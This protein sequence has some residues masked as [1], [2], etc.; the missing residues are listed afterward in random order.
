MKLHDV[1]IE[2]V[3]KLFAWIISEYGNLSGYVVLFRNI[4]N[5]GKAC[6]LYW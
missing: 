6:A 4:V 1:V 2:T 3:S 5:Y